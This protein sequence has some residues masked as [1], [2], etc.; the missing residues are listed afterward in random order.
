[1]VCELKEGVGIFRPRQ[2]EQT[3]FNK[4]DERFYPAFKSVYDEPYLKFR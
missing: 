2:P 4:L 3:P 1:M